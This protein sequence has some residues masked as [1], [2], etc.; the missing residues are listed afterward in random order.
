MTL[1]YRQDKRLKHKAVQTVAL[2]IAAFGIAGLSALWLLVF[3]GMSALWSL[4]RAGASALWSV[5]TAA[6]RPR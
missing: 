6:V 3:A 4:L 5:L 1:A 2:G